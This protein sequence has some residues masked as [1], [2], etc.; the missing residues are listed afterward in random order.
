MTVRIF[1]IALAL[2]LLAK[3]GPSS[4]RPHSGF[5]I[6]R[7]LQAE[8]GYAW[9]PMA[10]WLILLLVVPAIV[11]PVVLLVGFTGCSFEPGTVPPPL[12]EPIFEQDLFA[13]P[14][15]DEA[16]WEGYCLVQLIRSSRLS[17]GGSKV[18]LTVRASSMSAASIDRIFISQPDP[19]LGDDYDSAADLKGLTPDTPFVVPANEAVTLPVIIYDLDPDQNLLIAVDF[20][21]A[22]ASGIRFTDAS[23]E[24]VVGFFSPPPP[25]GGT[26]HEAA[27]NNRTPGYTPLNGRL[28]FIEKIEVSEP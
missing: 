21:A 6:P 17:K 10:E 24:G 25:P 9:S 15:A 2:H 16:G 28:Y 20:S 27:V 5:E 3:S 23:P 8:F 22:P 7:E 4:R 26:F 12:F 11:V 19:A 18:R 13:A 14:S 1:G